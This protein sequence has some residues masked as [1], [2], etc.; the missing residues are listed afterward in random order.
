M[1]VII[2]ILQ[3]EFR[4]IFRNRAMIPIIFVMPIVQLLILVNAADFEI[5]NINIAFHDLD[6]SQSSKRLIGLFEASTYFKV[7][8]Q[9][10]S[11][12]EGFVE[13]DANRSTVL[14]R[15]PPHFERD[16]HK[17]SST[18]LAVDLNGIDG[19]AAGLSNYYVSQI[20]QQFNKNIAME[21]RGIAGDIRTP[22]TVQERYWFNP[23]LEYKNYMLPGLLVILV[24]MIGAFLSSMNIVREMELGT[25]E[26]INV[27]PIKKY[28]FIIGKLFPFWII[29]MF[30]L[31]FGLFIGL[32]IYSIPIEG[33]LL[34]LFSFAAIYLLV[35]LGLGLLVSTLTQTQQQ[36]M[37][38]SWFFLVI[39]LLMSGLFTPIENMPLWAQKITWFNPIAYFIDVVRLVL[40]KGSSFI[41]VR[42]HF[43]IITLFALVMNFFAVLNYRKRAA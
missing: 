20:V 35:V 16:L 29:G 34:I 28:Q 41:D 26:Q 21:T 33:N 11:F 19:S 10:R 25:I 36:A 37:F 18:E 9:A 4:Q 1:N 23:E 43:L 3:K 24:T 2:F 22:I 40:L 12:Q 42:N 39:F 5:R 17:A 31:A 6:Q 32:L 13:L 38:V 8:G 30:E 14:I 15:I 27:T 7:D